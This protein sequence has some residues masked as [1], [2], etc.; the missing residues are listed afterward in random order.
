MEK[1]PGAVDVLHAGRD[2]LLL[3]REKAELSSGYARPVETVSRHV[4]TLPSI[5][6]ACRGNTAECC[7]SKKIAGWP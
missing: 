6:W 1:K 2:R 3:L 4:R 7:A 5:R